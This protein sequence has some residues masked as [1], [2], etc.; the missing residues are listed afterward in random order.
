L[1]FTPEGDKL[2]IIIQAERSE[3]LELLRRN[4]ESFSADLRQAG[5]ASTSFSF[6]G[7]GQAP[8]SRSVPKQE[9]PANAFGSAEETQAKPAPY[10][11][12]I[13]RSGLDLRV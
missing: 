2:R 10:A 4:T 12:P 6:A 3:T 8:P 7:W 11:S 9:K 13:K 1:V 5:Y